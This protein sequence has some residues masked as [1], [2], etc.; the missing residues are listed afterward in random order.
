MSTLWLIYYGVFFRTVNPTENFS[1]GAVP[2]P[3]L[4]S[5]KNPL[6]CA[7]PNVANEPACV[8]V[9][10]L[11]PQKDDGRTAA[12]IERPTRTAEI[13]VIEELEVD[14]CEREIAA[15][16]AV[17]GGFEPEV[18]KQLRGFEMGADRDLFRVDRPSTL[19]PDALRVGA[20]GYQKEDR[21]S[22]QPNEKSS[23]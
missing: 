14:G 13:D 22:E 10:L 16:P 18:W 21:G 20:A 2:P 1:D 6:S 15:E 8:L 17:D 4:K 23:R 3:S 7:K 12:L 5:V 9:L 19:E 11:M